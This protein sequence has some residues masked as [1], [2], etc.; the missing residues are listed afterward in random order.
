LSELPANY[1]IFGEHLEL[2]KRIHK[3]VQSLGNDI[4]EDVRM[5]RIVYGR[6]TVLRTFLD[7]HPAKNGIMMTIRKGRFYN[8]AK[9]ITTDKGLTAEVVINN[10]NLKDA[11]E[12]VKQSYL[13]V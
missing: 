8:D 1:R 7:I 9:K 6:K 3:E 10:N 4:V 2:L 12:L 13:S 11:L 5:H